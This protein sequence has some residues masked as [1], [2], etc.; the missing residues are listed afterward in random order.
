MIMLAK[1]WFAKVVLVAALLFG[2]ERPPA[3]AAE[4]ATL[5]PCWVRLLKRWAAPT[6]TAEARTDSEA[7]EDG[8]A[9]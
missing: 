6:G 9:A 7:G 4:M 5:R 1:I 3:R 2:K 8:L